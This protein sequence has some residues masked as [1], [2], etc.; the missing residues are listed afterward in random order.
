MSA[1]SIPH[2]LRIFVIENHTDTLKYFKM[3]LEMEGHTV[4]DAQTIQQAYETLPGAGCD[5][6]ISDVGLPDGTGWDLLTRLREEGLPHP[7][8]A[9]AVSGYGS[10]E[11]RERSRVAGFRHHLLKPFDPDNL[12]EL[13]AEAAREF[14]MAR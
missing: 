5:V 1:T 14:A 13:L 8:F 11:D 9:I 12:D 6:L 7:P 2:P 10:L 4:L 3:Y